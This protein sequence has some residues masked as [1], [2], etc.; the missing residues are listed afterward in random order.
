MIHEIERRLRLV[1]LVVSDVDGTLARRIHLDHEGK[2]I[3]V[4][5]EKDAPRI[6]AIIRSGIHFAMISGRNSTAARVRAKELGAN[7]FHRAEMLEGEIGDPLSFLEHRY[8]V[9]RNEILYIG[10]DWGDLWWMSQVLI[11]AAPADA[12]EVCL[13]Q[14]QIVTKCNGGE[15]VV[16]EV[17]IMLLRAQGLYDEVVA[18][19]YKQPKLKPTT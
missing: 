17:L 14:A 10:D 5:C 6:A 11:A 9:S 2:E 19:Q 4:F 15:G 7:F 8:N 18:E 1:H 16:S 3:K 12:E 13:R